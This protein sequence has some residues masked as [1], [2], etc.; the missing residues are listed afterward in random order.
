MPLKVLLA[1]AAVLAVTAGLLLPM[2]HDNKAQA[3]PQIQTRSVS[4]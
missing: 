4:R 2:P 3:T 1:G